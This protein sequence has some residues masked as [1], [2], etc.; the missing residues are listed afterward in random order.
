MTLSVVIATKDRASFLDRALESLAEQRDAPSFDVVV[1]DNGSSDGTAE[2]VARHAAAGAYPLRVTYVPEPNRGAARNR[3]VAASNGDVVVFV[4][5]DVMLPRGFLAGHARAHD[6]LFPVAV[7]GPI[8]NVASYD[9]L[10][11][12]TL[13]HASRAFFCTCNASLLRS[14][15]DAVGGFDERFDLYGWEDTE[16][17][18]RLRRHDVRRVFAW[19]AYLYHIKPPEV[20]TLDAVLRK[21]TEKARMAARLVAKDPTIRTRLATGAYA[22]NLIRAAVVAPG[23]ALPWYAAAARSDR[24][25][26]S[27]RAFARAQYLDGAYARE[28]RAALRA[29]AG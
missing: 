2:V 24:L 14:T 1:A 23:W 4:D 21:T 28:L 3:G 19:D 7:A 11:R 18:I 8:I 12:P 5:D 16:L 29:G 22:A 17:G 10:P 25:P 26:P 9:S 13:A 15:F 20:E 27:L 6:T